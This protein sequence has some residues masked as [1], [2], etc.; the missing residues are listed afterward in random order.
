MREVAHEEIEESE[1]ITNFLSET[2]AEILDQLAVRAEKAR[3][4]QQA[5]Q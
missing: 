4:Q 1:E 5:D 3:S 2:F